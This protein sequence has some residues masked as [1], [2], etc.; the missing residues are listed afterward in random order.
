MSAF[1]LSYY[2]LI[3]ALLVMAVVFLVL[4][5]PGNASAG[6]FKISLRI[7]SVLYVS[8]SAYCFFKMT[9]PIDVLGMPFL[10]E[11][12]VQAHL[13]GI[14]YLNV[15]NS[16]RINRS[17]VV[18]ALGQPLVLALIGLLCKNFFGY[19]KVAS[20][21]ELFSLVSFDRPDLYMRIIWFVYYIS[22][23]VFYLKVFF[24]EAAETKDKDWD[25]DLA[26]QRLHFA[27]MGF[28]I[29]SLVVLDTMFI[30]LCNDQYWCSVFNLFILMLYVIIGVIIIRSVRCY[31]YSGEEAGATKEDDWL[32]WR[33]SI[34][35]KE[36]YTQQGITIVQI[37]RELNT[38]RTTLS[39]VINQ[40]EGGNFNSF[41][42]GLRISKAQTLIK[43]NPLMQMAD[44]CTRVGYTD[45]ANFS[46]HFKQITGLSPI[47]WKQKSF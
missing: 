10:F 25:D 26:L 22:V 8:L 27:K 17:F 38:N 23:A 11:A 28:A 32:K 47:A 15:I 16:P 13:W 18:K 4:P 3:V 9:Y 39:S 33:Q 40:Y 45:Q 5:V 2:L 36:L 19:H 7:F 6:K 24:D 21:T 37:A 34:I 20:I 35:D 42:N 29:C 30:T 31:L 14:A 44:V 1:S 12:T 46:R 41:I 43:E